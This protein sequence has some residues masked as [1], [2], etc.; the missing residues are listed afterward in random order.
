M[1]ANTAAQNSFESSNRFERSFES[2]VTSLDVLADSHSAAGAARASKPS[3]S[4]LA[5]KFWIG[6]A[7]GSALYLAAAG[8]AV[9]S[10]AGDVG[11][12]IELAP[13]ISALANL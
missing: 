3:K 13:E 8:I 1:T 6:L 7:T 12:N 9:T 10:I 2:S 11:N 5:K 4:G